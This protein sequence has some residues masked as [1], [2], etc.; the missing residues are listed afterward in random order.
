MASVLGE[1]ILEQQLPSGREEVNSDDEGCI[2][3]GP[4]VD[5]EYVDLKVGRES[6]EE[7]SHCFNDSIIRISNVSIDNEE[8]SSVKKSHGFGATSSQQRRRE[9]LLDLQRKRRDEI[10]DKIRQ[11]EEAAY[12]ESETEDEMDF[13]TCIRNTSSYQTKL[14]SIQEMENMETTVNCT[15]S[16]A[17]RRGKNRNRRR[18]P[19]PCRVMLSEWL[20]DKPEDFEEQWIGTLCPVGKRCIVVANRGK[21]KVFSRSD[22]YLG[23]FKSLLPGG[24]HVNRCKGVTILDCIWS[25]QSQI[26]YVLDLICWN[27]HSC[28]N[29]DTDYR[30]FF[31]HSK[32]S[33]S[34]ELLEC[35]KFNPYPFKPLPYFPA[36][37][38]PLVMA[39]AVTFPENVDGILLIHKETFYVPETNP[40][41]LWILPSDVESALGLY[42]SPDLLA[43]QDKVKTGRRNMKKRN[44]I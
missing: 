9:R 42:V 16:K 19:P 32:F 6:G 1:E 8:R 21:T 27:S 29:C 14:E 22:E 33:E 34:L 2:G 35:S 38:M 12:S 3:S 40:L 30:Q 17:K 39:S 37:E 36:R 28:V 4:A 5:V 31:L 25:I 43:R 41:C 18:K 20:I 15:S 13:T 7:R 24:S 44:G 11:L 26:F 10:L 23:S